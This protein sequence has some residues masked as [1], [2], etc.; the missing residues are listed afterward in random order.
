[1]SLIFKSTVLSSVQSTVQRVA[2][3]LGL[4]LFLI[5]AAPAFA[6]SGG[7]GTIQGTVTDP[8]G[9]IIPGASVTVVETATGEAHSQKSTGAGFYSIGSLNPGNYTVTVTAQGFEKYVQ[10]NVTLDALQVLGLNTP[11]KVGGGDETVTISTAPP[12]LDT[13]NGTLGATIENETYEALPLNMGGAP[14]DPTAFV[15]LAP[16]VAGASSPY[17][18]FNGGQGYHNEVYIEGIATT[19]SAAAGGGNT[20]SVVRGAS[21]DAVDQFQVQTSGTSAAFQGQGVENYTLKSGTNSY[22]GRAFEYF[23]NTVLDTWGFFSKAQINPATGQPS[24]PVERQ[25]EYGGTFGGPVTIPHLLNGKDKLF[26]FVSYD[27]QRYLKGANPSFVTVP[28]VA[29]RAGDFSAAG[30]QPIYDPAT[31]VCNGSGSACT[32]Q[33]FVSDASNTGIPVGTKN[34]IPV[35]RQSPQMLYYQN[36]IPLPSN[37]NLTNNYLSGFNTGF[38]YYKFSA[39]VDYNITKKDRLTFLFLTGNRA[40]LPACCDSSGLPPPFTATV[41]NFQTYPTG[42]IEETHTINDHWINQFKYAVIR[43]SG[44]STNPAEGLPAYAATAAGITNVLPGQ[45]SM[46]APR[47]GLSGNNAPASLGGT[48]NSN[49]QANSEYGDSFVLYDTM[50]LVKG[51]HSMNFGGQYAWEEDNDTTLTTGTYLNLNYAPAETA[52][53][54]ANTVTPITT[55]GLGYASYLLGAVDNYSQVDNRLALTTGARFYSFSPFF[56]DDI[57][58]RPNLTIN[59]GIRWD[60]YSSFRE[61][62]NRLS[63]LDPNTINPIT[64]TPGVLTF[65]GSGAGTCNCTRASKIP[66]KNFSP[67]LGFSYSAHPTTVIRGSFDL[68]FTHDGGVGG[69]GGAR[70]GASQLGF[71]SNNTT[72]SPNGYAPALFLN[73]QNS[74]LATVTPPTRTSTF[75]T[76]YT[77]TA[78]F[79]TAGQGLA[80][81]DQYL[82]T[83]APYYMNFNFG[84]QQSLTQMMTVSLDYSG[85][86]GRF[87]PTG[88]GNYAN[89]GQLDPKYNVLGK[90]LS[91]PANAANVAAAQAIIPSYQLPFPNFNPTFTIGQS[92]RPFPQYNGITDVYGDFGRSSYNSFIAVLAQ[93]PRHGLSFTLNYTWSKLFDNTGTGRTAYHNEVATQERSLS[94]YNHPQNISSYAVYAEPFGKGGH[95]TDHLIRNFEI[96]GIYTFTSGTPLAVT[97][98]GCVTVL[99]GTCEPN[100]NPAFVGSA[101]INGT[102]GHGY[103]AAQ[104]AS[105]PFIDKNAFSTPAAYTY[106]NAPRTAPY[107]LSSPG[108]YNIN[109]SLRRSFGIFEGLKLVMQIDAINVTNHT[110]FNAPATGVSSSNFGT[111]T[112]TNGS[113]DLQLAARIDF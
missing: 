72:V 60:L 45:A 36:Y 17:G 112:G 39:K 30:N 9:A 19:N 59:A 5:L 37:A 83:R 95:F 11:L 48:A 77:T 28:T 74:A 47:I 33:Q 111:I 51:R 55:T 92:L 110:N 104:L 66:Y 89:S 101:R 52:N 34:V 27:G 46:A 98:T 13:S 63:F 102:Y 7:K 65:A 53:F 40:A 20:A 106:G 23:R 18:S 69:R 73:S 35:S 56:Q 67:H 107:G 94:L 81:V 105:T 80:F 79:N 21:V 86:N 54:T 113:R 99:S 71:S 6:Q 76:G 87:L 1:M 96:S 61:V 14:R 4:A 70:Q 10:Q 15:F 62:Q 44:Y 88:A 58:L 32:R 26:F 100:L 38:T 84:I 49:N 8:S 109:M 31:T 41:G 97:S 93:K 75:G 108:G 25:N 29:Q 22:H 3:F 90:L 2:V 78:G 68:A 91:S 57:K 24:K 50:Q 16:G 12:T 82:S 85:S 43:S 42:I 64:G 103:T